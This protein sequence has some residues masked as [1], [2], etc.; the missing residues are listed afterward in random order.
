[1]L[2]SLKV[3]L[4]ISDADV[5][6]L[7]GDYKAILDKLSAL[8][9][10]KLITAV[11]QPEFEKTVLPLLAVFDPGDLLKALFDQLTRVEDDLKAEMGRVNGWR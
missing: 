10:G 11:V 3:N 7:D 1:M 8:D 9:P 6:K 2:D 4:L 5:A